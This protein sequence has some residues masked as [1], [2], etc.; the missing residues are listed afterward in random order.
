MPITSPVLQEKVASLVGHQGVPDTLLL[1]Q[2]NLAITYF[3]CARAHQRTLQNEKRALKDL[4]GVQHQPI[5]TVGK[6][7]TEAD[8]K[9]SRE[10]LHG[11]EVEL[12]PRGG[13]TTFHGPGQVPAQC[14]SQSH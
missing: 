6:R 5:Y 12:V 11:A 3:D 14:C 8:F 9:V 7:G 13:E 10:E 1:L 2:V 4:H